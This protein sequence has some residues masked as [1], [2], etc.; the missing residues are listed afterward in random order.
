MG[1]KDRA[2]KSR[3]TIKMSNLTRR[4]AR[5]I[6]LT[7]LFESEFRTDEDYREIYATSAEERLIPEDGYIK[8]AYYRIFEEREAIDETIGKYAKGWKTARLSKLSRSVLRL[9]VYEMLYEDTIPYSVTINEVVELTKKYDEP[10]AR[11]FVN[12]VLN[13]V[14][15]ALVEE[16]KNK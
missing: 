7:L 3:A 2:E 12:G 10:R 9:G 11:A 16:G 14:K 1:G 4:E 8:T 13:A 5:E 6:L 15:D